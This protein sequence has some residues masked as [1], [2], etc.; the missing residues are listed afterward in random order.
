MK[1]ERNI[2]LRGISFELG[3]DDFDT[4]IEIVQIVENETRYFALGYI[5]KRL[6]ALVYTLR[7]N[8]IRVISLRKFNK[9]EVKKYG[10]FK[11]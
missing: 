3:H 1:N 8:I 5:N 6:Y 9:R 10:Q 11:N 2:K 4:A 7:V